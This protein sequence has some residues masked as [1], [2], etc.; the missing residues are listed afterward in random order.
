MKSLTIRLA[1]GVGTLAVLSGLLPIAHAQETA[2][3]NKLVIGT[4]TVTAQRREE[5]LQSVPVTVTAFSGAEIELKGIDN[6]Q[7][8]IAAT[9]GISMDAFPK[10]A[11]RPFIR[12]IGSGN[13]S[14]GAD[15]SSVAFV[16]GVY[17]GRGPMLSVDIFDVE[18]V[19]V[20]KGPQG[21][22]WGKNVVGGAVHYITQKPVDEFQAKAQMTI[23][24]YGQKDARLVLNTPLS[25][26]LSTRLSL[27]SIKNDGFRTNLIDGGP[28]DDDE[29]ISGRFHALYDLSDQS[30]LLFSIDGTKDE[31]A[32]PA[33]FNLGPNNYED[34]DD[35]DIATPDSPGFLSRETW[36]TKLEYTSTALNWAEVTAYVSYRSLDNSTQ[37]DFD[38]T[39]PAGNAAAGFPL[40][41]INVVMAEGAESVSAEARLATTFDGPFNFV[42]GGFALQDTIDR[43]RESII[44]TQ[45]SSTNRYIARNVTDSIGLFVDGRYQV[46]DQWGVFGGIR[47]TDEQKEYSIRHQVGD[48]GTPTVDFTTFGDPGIAD[49]QQW[50]WRAGTDY[51]LTPDIFLFG[52]V[53]TGFKSGAFEEQPGED[54]ARLATDPETVINY[55]FGAKTDF[56]GGRGRANVSLFHTEYS[57]LQTIQAVDDASLDVGLTTIVT[58][59]GDATIEGIETEFQWLATDNL[60]FG[61]LYTYLDA[62]FEHFVET[63]E[64]LADGTRV[65]SDLSGNMLSRT[66]KNAA[67][68]SGIYRTDVYDWGALSM[69]VEVN[70]QSKIYDDNSNNEIE[71][72]EPRTLLDAHI[73]YEPTENV[74]LKLWGR[75]L[76]DEVYRAHQAEVAGGLFVQYGAPRQIGLTATLEF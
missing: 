23:A 12:G 41:G 64:I 52:T 56:W 27:S 40:P 75:N 20:L 50:T 32:G 25:D 55:E 38:G 43:E 54:T 37:E 21:T 11:P 67:S 14:G 6:V 49:E 30:S 68:L 70:Y 62:T 61:L 24:D 33:R 66:P 73:T 8:L 16:D 28:L 46:S 34:L 9:P 58:D 15:P 72:R 26:A 2:E 48:R 36:G 29:R 74:K 35:P 7:S 1:A 71:S 45:E 22:L 65:L 10:T 69:G 47:L 39:T 53:S 42:A 3:E 31:A 19:E 76:T 13:Q 44:A 4:V 60:R 5:T 57:D 63:D 51:Q 59:T 18:R 17:L